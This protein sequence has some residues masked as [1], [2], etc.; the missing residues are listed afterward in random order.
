MSRQRQPPE[1]RR[2][3]ILEGALPLMSERGVRKVTMRDIA[4]VAGVS[5]GTVSY[6]FTGVR[7]L[8]SEAIALDIAR[9][10]DPVLAAAR[11]A[12]DADA[13]L[14]VLLDAVFTDDTERHWRLW[15]D[16]WGAAEDDEIARGQAQRYEQ[17]QSE[18]RALIV[19]G[20]DDNDFD[21]ADADEAAVLFVAVVD[22][23]ALQ[24]IRGVPPLTG[25]DARRHLYR[26]AADQLKPR[27]PNW[28]DAPS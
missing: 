5:L 20:T 7:E 10:Y 19:R 4:A 2:R 9:Y 3:M 6:H 15:F 24:R 18:I 11:D 8:L 25:E 22:G 14:R 12:T 21:P 13:G 27:R 26:F 16:W 28:L 17:W 23:L 1:V